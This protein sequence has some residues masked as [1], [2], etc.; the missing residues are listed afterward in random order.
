[1]MRLIIGGIV[2]F[3]VGGGAGWFVR[4][5]PCSAADPQ[6]VADY[7]HQ[8]TMQIPAPTEAQLER[9]SVDQRESAVT[10]APRPAD[11]PPPLTVREAAQLLTTTIR[12]NAVWDGSEEL[13]A[14]KYSGLNAGELRAAYDVVKGECDRERQTIV[15]EKFKLGL[16]DVVSSGSDNPAPEIKTRP[17]GGPLSFGFRQEVQGTTVISKVTTISPEEYP[18]YRALELEWAWLDRQVNSMKGQ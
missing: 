10:E 12:K 6:T 3:L 8:Q 13:L 18:A 1:M 7:P 2:L 5:T 17:G 9:A 15:D 4:G 11:S 14:Q 16:Y